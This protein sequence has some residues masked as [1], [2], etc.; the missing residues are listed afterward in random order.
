MKRVAKLEEKLKAEKASHAET[1]SLLKDSRAYFH[2]HTRL[3]QPPAEGED[4]TAPRQPMN[5][6]DIQWQKQYEA[7]GRYKDKYGHTNVPS[8]GDHDD[9]FPSLANWVRTQRKGFNDLKLGK[10]SFLTPYR[11]ALLRRVD[12]EWNPKGREEV[13]WETRM[14]QLAA[15]KE[16]HGN[17]LVPQFYKDVP[18]LGEW[19]LHM[20][21]TYRDSQLSQ[22][23]IAKMEELG[24]QWR[25]RAPPR[26]GRQRAAAT[27]NGDSNKDD[28]DSDAEPCPI[29]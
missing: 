23:R 11:I 10:K 9:E 16:E 19:V 28:S 4:I 1:K 15:Y 5:F 2:R 25:L 13:K 22:D 24:F 6:N 20:R 8:N 27:R 3:I 14:E 26:G 21:R 7:L 29:I 18:G 17:C 12:F